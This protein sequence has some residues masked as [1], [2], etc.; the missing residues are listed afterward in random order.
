MSH[1]SSEEY[2][3]SGGMECPVCEG[4][5]LTT[6]QS[7][8]YGQNIRQ[9]VTCGDCDAIWTDVYTLSRYEDLEPM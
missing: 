6:D 5:D 8:T 4:S 3:K 2:A 7:K 9:S 1:T